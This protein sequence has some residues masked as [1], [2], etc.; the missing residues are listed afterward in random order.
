MK[1]D[2]GTKKNIIVLLKYLNPKSAKFTLT[3][4]D[5]ISSYQIRL[6]ESLLSGTFLLDVVPS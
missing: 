4:L 2:S 3:Y 6:K 5:S 1:Y